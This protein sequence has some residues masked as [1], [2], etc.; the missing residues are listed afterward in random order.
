MMGTGNLQTP[1][2]NPNPNPDPMLTPNTHS[3][4][5]WCRCQEIGGNVLDPE[6][7]W[8]D[9]R[10]HFLVTNRGINSTTRCWCHILIHPHLH[11]R[12]ATSQKT[13]AHQHG[14]PPQPKRLRLRFLPVQLYNE[15]RRGPWRRR[16]L[17]Y[18]CPR[19]SLKCITLYASLTPTLTLFTGP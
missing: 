7:A 3:R 1:N 13:G 14:L 16:M 4:C 10:K 5:F 11:C 6:I 12:N 15:L 18:W 19:R 8:R 17:P 2:P 9:R